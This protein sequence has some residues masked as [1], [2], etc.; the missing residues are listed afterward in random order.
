MDALA[1]GVA[2]PAQ[3]EGWLDVLRGAGIDG[4]TLTT[5]VIIGLVLLALYKM[6]MLRTK[7]GKDEAAPAAD[8]GGA[9]LQ[10]ITG[11]TKEIADQGRATIE[12]I[13]S[14]KRGIEERLADH[15]QRDNERF[16]TVFG[17]IN[18]KPQSPGR[19][20]RNKAVFGK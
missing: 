19:I 17:L 15:E 6:G 12:H 3:A 11:I 16:D 9:I 18:G 2:D 7:G 20:E 10:A 13:D 1:Q 8:Q 4:G 14:V 5:L